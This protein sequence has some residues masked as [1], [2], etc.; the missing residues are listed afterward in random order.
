MEKSKKTTLHVKLFL[1]SE[2]LFFLMIIGW[3]LTEIVFPLPEY[4]QLRMIEDHEKW[5]PRFWDNAVIVLFEFGSPVIFLMSL[6]GI[7]LSLKKFLP[8]KSCL[9]EI[10]AVFLMFLS[11]IVFCF[12][13]IIPLLFGITVIIFFVSLFKIIRTIKNLRKKNVSVKEIIMFCIM[14]FNFI[15]YSSILTVYTVFCCWGEL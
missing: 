9:K 14:I 6:V 11:F 4:I 3:V 5:S 7:I 13:R 2:I 15:I 1:I 8:E 10:L 12:F